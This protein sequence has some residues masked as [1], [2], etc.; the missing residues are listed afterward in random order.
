MNYLQTAS[1]N[2]NSPMPL[3]VLGVAFLA[4]GI[5]GW[6]AGNLLKEWLRR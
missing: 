6:Y 3:F 5:A 4:A 1:E 2:L